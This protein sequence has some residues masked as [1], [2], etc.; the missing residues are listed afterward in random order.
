MHLKQVLNAAVD[1]R[2]IPSNP[3][4]KLRLPRH[5]P[6][7][8]VIPTV[9]E[10]DA[11]RNNIDERFRALVVV[12]LGLGLRQGEVFGLSIDRV[13][14]LRREVK[15]D[16]QLKRQER[17][18]ILGTLKTDNSYRTIPLPDLVGDELALHLERFPNDDPDGLLF[19]A[20]QGGRLRADSWGRRTWKPAVLAAG[21]P[22]LGFHSLRHFYA[23]AL[24]RDGQSAA[25][26]SR[27]LGNT[28]AMVNETYSHLWPD[29]DDRTRSTIDGLFSPT[30]AK[31]E[32]G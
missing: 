31:R 12:G 18:T 8:M 5:V 13:D 24:I 11:I 1:D 17:G 32:A 19:V 27:R 7:E 9:E 23:S 20:S 15:I 4:K 25:A 14:F 16:R 6:V 3:A 21:R 30:A 28:A 29:E 26:V 22:E 10:V 2:M